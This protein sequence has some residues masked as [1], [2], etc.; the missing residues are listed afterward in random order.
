MHI[1]ALLATYNEERFIANCLEN[2]FRQGAEVYL[3]DNE[4]T[5]GTVAI[6]ERYRGRGL[7]GV[8]TLPRAGVFS[9]RAQMQ[10]KEQLA[11]QLEADWFIHTDADEIRL[12]PCSGSTLAQALAEVEAEG[13]NAVNFAEFAFIPTREAPDHDHP[14]YLQTMRWYY[15]FAPAPLHRLNAWRRQR[16]AVDLTSSGGHQVRFPGARVY[17]RPFIMKHYLFLSV[18]HAIDKFV[19]RRFDPD[20]I[21]MGW[22]AWR[23]RLRPEMIRLPCQAELRPFTSNDE[24]DASN[25]RRTHYL[26]DLI[27]AQPQ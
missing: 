20:E 4:S 27:G 26:A 22:H 6:A 25:P 24:L 5:D 7:I 8:E 17:P 13:Y 11:A 15:P 3:I 21:R 16:H 19:R 9:L 2:L 14:A 1:V 10:R 18:P 23:S 12:P